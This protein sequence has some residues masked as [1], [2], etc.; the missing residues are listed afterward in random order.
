MVLEE[1]AS[2][3]LTSLGVPPFRCFCFET[4]NQN[5]KTEEAVAKKGTYISL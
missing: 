1:F 2:G 5:K 4:L 3:E